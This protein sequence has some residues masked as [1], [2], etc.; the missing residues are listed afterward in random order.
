MKKHAI[1][2]RRWFQGK[3]PCKHLV[4]QL[5]VKSRESYLKFFAQF[6]GA[7]PL[8]SYPAKWHI[9]H[10][11]PLH[12]F[13]EKEIGLA[14][15][16]ENL[17]PL[18]PHTNRIKGGSLHESLYEIERRLESFPTNENLAK[19]RAKLKEN[20]QDDNIKLIFFFKN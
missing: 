3:S 17:R 16:Q 11:V 13:T 5:D 4:S 18:I 12:L 1:A 9:D 15:S 19:L 8:S 20:W 6:V 10:V 14:W 7:D 2:F